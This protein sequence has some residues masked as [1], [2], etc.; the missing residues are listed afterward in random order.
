MFLVSLSKVR[1]GF[2][3]EYC[4]GSLSFVAIPA[5]LIIFLIKLVGMPLFNILRDKLK[6]RF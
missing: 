6:Y 5:V 4:R 3:K 1:V 2:Y